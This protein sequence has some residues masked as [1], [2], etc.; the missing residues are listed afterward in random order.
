VQIKL[1]AEARSGE[2]EIAYQFVIIE[3]IKIAGDFHWPVAAIHG[4]QHSSYM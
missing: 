2:L 3:E 1:F 4:L